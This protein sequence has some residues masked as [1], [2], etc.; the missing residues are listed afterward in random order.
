MIERLA[1][2]LAQTL[3]DNIDLQVSLDPELPSLHVD[4][5]RLEAA[6]IALVVNAREAMPSGGRLAISSG[7]GKASGTHPTLEPNRPYVQIT[8]SDTGPGIPE[9]LLDRVLEPLFTTKTGGTGLG[10]G[11]SVA[12]GFVQQTRGAL[13]MDSELGRGTRVTLNFPP[14]D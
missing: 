13:S 12:N 3:P 9:D 1:Q 6:I 11:L 2:L 5:D 10:L 7:A 4:P 8:V 14:A